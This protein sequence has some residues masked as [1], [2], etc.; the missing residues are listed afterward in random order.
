MT[1]KYYIQNTYIW[2][3]KVY[4]S[5]HGASLKYIIY[6]SIAYV[7]IIDLFFESNRYIFYIF[8]YV[9]FQ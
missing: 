2:K 7:T 4:L 9:Y 5:Y 3:R 6:S 1:T 8:I